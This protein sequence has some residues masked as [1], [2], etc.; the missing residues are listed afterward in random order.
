MRKGYDAELVF[1]KKGQIIAIA[2]GSDACSEHEWGTAKLQQAL[3]SKDSK[4]LGEEVV[5]ALKTGAQA[6]YPDLFECK[7]LD[8]NLDQLVFVE[9]QEEGEPVAVFGFSPYHNVKVDHYELRLWCEHTVTGAWDEQSFAIKVKGAKLVKKLRTFAEK[10]KAGDAVFSGTFWPKKMAGVNL[11]LCSE[12]R[13][14]HLAP[15]KKAQSEWEANLRLAARSRV[16]EFYASMRE[17]KRDAWKYFTHIWP[18]WRNQEVDGDVVY[19]VNEGFEARD[20]IGYYGPYTFE[21]LMA[22]IQADKKYK[23][24]PVR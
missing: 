16:D 3:C 15:V 1:G 9:G 7:K 11:A 4:R 19:A 10:A 17:Q 18:V 8:K 6:P 23:L 13:H 21:A 5:K 20:L 2:T 22:W 12:L 24:E 14:E